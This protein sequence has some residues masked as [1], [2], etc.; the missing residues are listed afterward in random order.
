LTHLLTDPISDTINYEHIQ[1]RVGSLSFERLQAP[2][3]ITPAV[4][5]GNNHR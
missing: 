5:R 4:D 3:E 2:F 1:I